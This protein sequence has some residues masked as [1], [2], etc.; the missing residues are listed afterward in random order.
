MHQNTK[1]FSFLIDIKFTEIEHGTRFL[2]LLL[3]KLTLEGNGELAASGNANPK[4]MASVN[5]SQINTYK[6]KA[7]AI[8]RS[9]GSGIVKLT[10]ESKGLIRG[11]VLIEIKK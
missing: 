10:A 5:R 11:E 2:W 8:I 7:Q 9:S 3:I 4:D 1:S 6:G